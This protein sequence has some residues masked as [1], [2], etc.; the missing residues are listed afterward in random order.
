MGR[1]YFTKGTILPGVSNLLSSPASGEETPAPNWQPHLQ[2]SNLLSSP[3][4]GELAN[5]YDH[6]NQFIYVSNLL[7]SPASGESNGELQLHV[8]AFRFQFIEFPS[9]WGGVARPRNGLRTEQVSNLLSSPASG[10]LPGKH[11]R[12]GAPCFQFIEFPSEWGGPSKLLPICTSPCFQFIE[13]PSEW[14]GVAR[15]RN[16]LRTE[17]VSNLLSSPASG[18]L[19][20]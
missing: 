12:G 19:C 10:E 1:R 11:R 17:Q 13:F 4:S 8:R 15:P 20:C 18:E 2:V 5:S 14:G 3:A 6:V 16:G 9:E 7:S